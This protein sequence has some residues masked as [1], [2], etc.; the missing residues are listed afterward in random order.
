MDE[1]PRNSMSLEHY[2]YQQLTSE[3]SYLLEEIGIGSDEPTVIREDN[4]AA[5]TLSKAF[6][7]KTKRVKHFLLR[8]NYLQ[9]A[10][11]NKLIMIEYCPTDKMLADGLTK[12]VVPTKSFMFNKIL[13]DESEVK[14]V[15]VNSLKLKKTNGNVCIVCRFRQT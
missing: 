6:S 5:I 9:E 15:N 11:K 2:R 8:I 14:Y 3:C 10:V 1:K 7:G 4:M 12:H 13:G